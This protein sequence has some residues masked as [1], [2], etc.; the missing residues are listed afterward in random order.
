MVRARS[1]KMLAAIGFATFLGV[2]QASAAP[3]SAADTSGLRC[4]KIGSG[5]YKGCYTNWATCLA[6]SGFLRLQDQSCNLRAKARRHY[7]RRKR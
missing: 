4:Y 2:S 3:A 1:V 6:D 5:E 7:S